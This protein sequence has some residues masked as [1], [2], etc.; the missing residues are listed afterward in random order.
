MPA[1]RVCD[2]MSVLSGPARRLAS[3]LG[4]IAITTVIAVPGALAL[5]PIHVVFGPPTP[6]SK[7]VRVPQLVGLTLG[8]AERRL[9]ARGLRWAEP[10]ALRY[11]PPRLADAFQQ[12]AVVVAASGA[13]RRVVGQALSAGVLTPIGSVVA[14]TTVRAPGSPQ[15]TLPAEIR[16]LSLARDGR[17]LTI[18]FREG[19]ARCRPL[20]HVDLVPH[21]GWVVADVQIVIADSPTCDG[22]GPSAARTVRVQLPAALAGRPILDLEPTFPRGGLIDP[23]PSPWLR[24]YINPDRRTATVEYLAGVCDKLASVDATVSGGV[25]RV[26]VYEGLTQTLLPCAAVGFVQETFVRLPRA[27]RALVDGTQS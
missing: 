11:Q 18:G 16:T 4:T 25:A 1:L 2:D 3:S 13:D 15:L 19:P 12:H 8:A 26:T 24:G 5:S 22:S 23:R 10:G 7:I 9:L 6:S 20:D 27:A 17:T 14:L 21:S